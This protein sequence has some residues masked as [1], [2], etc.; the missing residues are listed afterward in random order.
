M[1]VPERTAATSSSGIAIAWTVP[2]GDDRRAL[3]AVS[4]RS[5]GSKSAPFA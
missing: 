5:V 3:W 4:L 2:R 1:S